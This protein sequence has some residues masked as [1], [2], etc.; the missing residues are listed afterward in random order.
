MGDAPDIV[1]EQMPNWHIAG[2]LGTATVFE[3]PGRW[4]A[5]NKRSGRFA[6]YG[7]SFE[8]TDGASTLSILDLAPT[9]LHL[10]GL[11]VPETMDG[12][13]AQSVFTPGSDPVTTDPTFVSEYGRTETPGSDVTSEARDR[14]ED[15]GYL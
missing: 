6:M 5:E 9:L 12:E 13:V 15:L 2:E 4:A 10:L 8:R 11:P 3:S 1:L 14:L 7:E